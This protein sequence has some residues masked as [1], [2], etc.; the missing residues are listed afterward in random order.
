MSDKTASDYRRIQI[1]GRGSYV[2]SLPKKWVSDMGLSKGERIAVFKQPDGSLSLVPK[3]ST[4]KEETRE[5]EYRVRG[6][7][8]SQA[9]MRRIVSLYLVGYNTIK[10]TLEGSRF[11]PIQRDAL[12]EFVRKKL[13]G[14]EIVTESSNEMSLQVLLSYPQLTAENA[15]KRMTTI[16]EWM[17]KEAVQ[18]I[19]EKSNE[20]GEEVARMDD[21]VD[22]FGFY[23][24]RQLKTALRNPQIIKE[25]GLS[26][27]IDLLGY[28]LVTKSVERTADHAVLIAKNV[29]NGQI[30]K[31]LSDRIQEIS[32]FASEIFDAAMKSLY[33]RDYKTAD[34]VISRAR[35]IESLEARAINEVSKSRLASEDIS[36]LRLALESLRRIAEYGSDI[37]EVVLNLTA[38]A[39]TTKNAL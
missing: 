22:R 29:V 23:I 8:D 37:A 38:I 27:P 3:E 18:S 7:T 33:N 13:M 28:R 36:S 26:S 6:D 20:L 35:E 15:L 11:S 32:D 5:I 19:M 24:V 16:A 9:I 4:G 30:N 21:E 25:L 31:P 12:R 14:T 2:V 17:H 39:A 34:V 10:I 1:T